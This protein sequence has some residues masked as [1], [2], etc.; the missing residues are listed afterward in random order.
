MRDDRMKGHRDMVTAYSNNMMQLLNASN[1][2]A[3]IT[4]NQR[5]V[6]GWYVELVG[7]LYDAIIIEHDIDTA[8]DILHDF[9]HPAATEVN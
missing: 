4:N 1:S 6:I 7:E 5:Q 8:A 2:L 3:E 9:T